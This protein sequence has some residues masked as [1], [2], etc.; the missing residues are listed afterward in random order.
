MNH[1]MPAVSQAT[2]IFD[3]LIRLKNAYPL[4]NF[5]QDA[6]KV[7]TE[8]LEDVDPSILLAAVIEFVRTSEKYPTPAAVR[9]MTR[10]AEE[11]AR[12]P[13]RFNDIGEAAPLSHRRHLLLEAA[14]CGDIDPAE[15]QQL[16]GD[17]RAS[18]RE[19]GADNLRRR[20]ETLGIVP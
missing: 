17:Y 12:G 15:W 1:I 5:D 6:V 20:Y 4:M 16:I 14:Y 18:G 19:F 9:R 11:A 2:T 8:A 10:W 13:V 3:S 7:W